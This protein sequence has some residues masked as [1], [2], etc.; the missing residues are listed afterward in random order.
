M[1]LDRRRLRLLPPFCARFHDFGLLNHRKAAL[2][3]LQLSVALFVHSVEY[4]RQHLALFAD[5]LRKRIHLLQSAF[6]VVWVLLV[7]DFGTFH[8]VRLADFVILERV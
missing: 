6:H 4:H 5:C 3:E 1:L 8:A 7:R 2:V